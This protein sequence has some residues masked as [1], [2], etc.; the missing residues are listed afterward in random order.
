[1]LKRHHWFYD[2]GEWVDT[3]I[4]CEHTEVELGIYTCENK[5]TFSITEENYK[6]F[7]DKNK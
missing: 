6:D 7:E 2:E 3:G 1:M 4:W 5:H